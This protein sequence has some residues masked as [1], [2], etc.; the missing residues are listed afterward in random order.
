[1]TTMT[2]RTLFEKVWDA[3]VVSQLPGGPALLYVDLHLV[4]EVTSPQ[5]FEGLRLA[6]RRVR[7]PD[8]TVATVDH[9]VSTGD[10]HLPIADE[11]S[12]RQIRALVENAREF[13]VQLFDL[14][15]P[16]QGIVHV[17]GPEL[18][19]TQP[20]MTIVCGDSHTSTH[21]A[22]GALAFGIGTTEVEHVLATQ[23]IVQ[24][25]PRTMEV[26]FAGMA[27]PG[28]SAKDLILALIRRIGIAGASGHVIEY[29]GPAIRALSMEGRMT[30]CNMSIEAGARAGMIAPDQVTS[31]YL[32]GRRH[33]PA[34]QAWEQAV[35]SWAL[36]RNDPGATYDRKVVMDAATVQPQVTWG[37]SPG[38]TADITERV[39]HPDQAPSE[40]DR[41]SYQ[42]ALEYMELRPG[43]P[44][45]GLKI[46]RVFVG[47]CTNA[48][49]E[50]LREAA[51]IARGRRVASGVRAMVVPG[52]RQVKAA[53]EREGLDRVFIEAGFEWRNPGCSMCLGMNEDVLGPGERCASTSNRNFEGR[54][55][56]GG[57][58][59]LM[60]PAMAAAAAI[61]G[62]LVDVRAY[63]KEFAARIDLPDSTIHT[64]TAPERYLLT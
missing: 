18:G 41:H 5:A 15:S 46:D 55:G 17:I 43:T 42:R 31:S 33:S 26:H 7:R 4:H 59:H 56:R 16:D 61:A 45:E 3:H 35:E 52:S 60:S 13:G 28:V 14:E 9:N 2:S 22:F 19:L 37:T 29:T 12:A 49:I 53:A 10:R 44:L 32:K 58:T 11:L 24:T 20:G 6:G 1:M 40:A 48:R 25:R 27:Q 21:G 64:E 63:L 23:C 51:Q 47:S 62:Y 54:Q 38:M 57:R 34:G 8:L 39:P 30:V 50:D 36:L